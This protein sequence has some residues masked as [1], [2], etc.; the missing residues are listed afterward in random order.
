MLILVI[1]HFL[2][3]RPVLPCASVHSSAV[4]AAGSLVLKFVPAYSIAGGSLR[5]NH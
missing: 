3:L 5:K 1:P 2:E 4:I